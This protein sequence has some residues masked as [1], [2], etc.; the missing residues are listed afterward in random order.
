MSSKRKPGLPSWFGKPGKYVQGVLDKRREY[1]EAER[2]RQNQERKKPVR[3]KPVPPKPKIESV[4]EDA[5]TAKARA[6]MSA[7]SA[8]QDCGATAVLFKRGCL[9]DQLLQNRME[10]L[11]RFSNHSDYI[12]PHVE[13]LGMRML[14]DD[15]VPV[16]VR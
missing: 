16:Q 4:V 3:R 6:F 2:R 12:G 8:I 14:Y 15:A 9:A 11:Q 10:A 1:D 7:L 5:L 13:V